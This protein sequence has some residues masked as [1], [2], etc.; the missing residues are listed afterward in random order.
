M[1]PYQISASTIHRKIKKQHIKIIN[2]K[3]QLQHGMINSSY[4]M[5]RRLYQINIH[6][7]VNRIENTPELNLKLNLNINLNF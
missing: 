3:Y 5:D 1:L 2:L 7:Y 6:V 4:Q